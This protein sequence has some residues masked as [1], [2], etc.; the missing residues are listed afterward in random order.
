MTIVGL[1]SANGFPEDPG[2]PARGAKDFETGFSSTF[3]LGEKPEIFSN[4]D[5]GN[6]EPN[7]ALFAE[8]AYPNSDSSLTGTDSN[9]PISDD[10]TY[11]L[12]AGASTDG[13]NAPMNQRI[14]SKRF[15]GQCP[16]ETEEK[17]T[18]CATEFYPVVLCCLGPRF[19]AFVIVNRCTSCR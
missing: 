7:T 11:Q 9:L 6:G 16:A 19:G 1:A 13:C 4:D 14:R 2:P 10:W 17:E 18:I 15:Q 12:D 3:D 5:W 8:M